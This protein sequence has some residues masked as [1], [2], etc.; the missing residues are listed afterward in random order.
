MLYDFAIIGGGIVGI[1]TARALL[2]AKPGASVVVIEKEPHL[3]AHQ[4]G[5]NSG[6]VHAG[7]YYEPGSLKAR[8]CKEGAQAVAD[9]CA[10]RNLPFERCGKLIVATNALELERL[11]A[12]EKRTEENGIAFERID[13]AELRRREPHIVGVG[14]L[15]IP[16]TAIVSY[17]AITSAMADDVKMLG[18]EIRL[19]AAVVAIREERDYVHIETT[20][21]AVRARGLIACAGLFA[22]RIAR[23]CGIEDDFR[24]VPFRGEYYRLGAGKNSIVKRLIY[25]VPDPALPFLGVHLTRMIDGSVTVGPNAVLSLKREGYGRFAFSLGDSLETLG[26]PGFQRAMGRNLRAG[27]DEFLN[28]LIK[29]RYL[30]QCRK[31]CPELEL[32]DFHPHPPGVRAQAIMRDGTM[33][34]D[35]LIRTTRRT[36]HVCNAPS[37]A[38]TSSIP[39]GE[40]VAKRAGALLS[41]AV[42]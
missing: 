4:T 30:A 40:A 5:R 9:Y 10:E 38:A 24:I 26:Y 12:L 31:Y 42:K 19:G 39:I 13:A 2:R 36:V 20:G 32:G 41:S 33:V 25:P 3:A 11:G 18:A 14:A 8:F 16:S 23:W 17:T 7:V 28:S 27:V 6:V 1:S 34:H 22:D 21:G 35:F 37:P 29:R 15:F